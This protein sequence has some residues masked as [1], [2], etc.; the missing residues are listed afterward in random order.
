[1][2]LKDLVALEAVLKA[3][4]ELEKP[5]QSRVLRWAAEKLD[6]GAVNG[7]PKRETPS[8]MSVGGLIAF[9]SVAEAVAASHARTDAERALVAAAFLSRKNGG[10]ELTGQEI[11]K[12]LKDAGHGIGN[13]TKAVNFL[14][15]RKPQLMVQTKKEGTSKQA[16]KNYKVTAAGFAAAEKLLQAPEKEQE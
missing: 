4:A 13:I 14:K 9:E 16:R 10:A 15:K 8:D 1:M 3:L 2:E 11:N 6:L 7:A 12:D 5:D